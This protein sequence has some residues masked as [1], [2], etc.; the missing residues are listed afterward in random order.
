[1][2]VRQAH[3]RAE[4]YMQQEHWH[5]VVQ[6]YLYCLEQ[7]R[8]AQDARAVRFFSARLYLAYEQMNMMPK[9]AYYRLMHVCG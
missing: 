2:A 9:A 5:L 8:I 3:I 4:A 1:M 6:H 7:A